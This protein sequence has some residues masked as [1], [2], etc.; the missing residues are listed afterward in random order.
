MTILPRTA[1]ILKIV[2][3]TASLTLRTKI[4]FLLVLYLQIEAQALSYYST[5]YKGPK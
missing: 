1:D 3:S 2:L 4:I 5:N